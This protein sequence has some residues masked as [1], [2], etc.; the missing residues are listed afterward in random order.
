[1]PVEIV[2]PKLGLTMTS[3]TV[4]RWI[5]Q[6]G[7]SVRAGEPLL[8]VATDK[9]NYEVE[10][11]AS[12]RLAANLAREGDEFACGAVLALIALADEADM[13]VTRC[14]PD[15]RSAALSAAANGAPAA[16]ASSP[17]RNDDRTG[18]RMIASPAA[19]RLA[20]ERGVSCAASAAPGRAA[21]SRSPTYGAPQAPSSARLRQYGAPAR[22]ARRFR[23]RPA[24][25][26]RST[27]R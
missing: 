6:P 17:E 25:G 3:G 20:R 19:R 2:M 5:K 13:P 21:A 4:A 8:E 11:P 24:A 7:E 22:R 12:G 23:R 1:M 15:R 14:G 27:A 26:V 10:A 18:R 9:I 16:A